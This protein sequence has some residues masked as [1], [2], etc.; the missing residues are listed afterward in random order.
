[1]IADWLDKLL[2]WLI[3]RFGGLELLQ[4]VLLWLTLQAVG[5]GFAAVTTS[6]VPIFMILLVTISTLAAWA[7]ARSRLSCWQFTLA[8]V[9]SGLISLALITGQIG[10][11]LLEL[12]ASPFKILIQ[13]FQ[14][15]RANP[16]LFTAAWQGLIES[17]RALAER[18]SNWLHSIGAGVPIT[19]PL[20][21]SFLWGMALW[22]MILWGVWWIQR[23]GSVLVG[24]LPVT[25]VLAFNIYYT[26]SRAG[27]SWLALAAGGV[28][29]LQAS[30]HFLHA[31]QR[32]EKHAMQREEA[33]STLA[34]AVIVL[35][36]A[37]VLTGRILPSIPIQK[38]AQSM[39]DFFSEPSDQ[40]LARSLGLE[41]TPPE[42]STPIY[43]T[44]TPVAGSG[45]TATENHVVGPGPKL[46]WAA[47]LF[48]TVEGYQPPPANA[49]ASSSPQY[50]LHYYWR[51]QTYSRYNGRFWSADTARVNEL[52]AGEPTLADKENI[53]QPPYATQVT[54]RITRLQIGDKSVYAAGEL[55]RLDVRALALR[56]ANG[57]LISARTDA[58]RYTAVSRIL[59]ASVDQ[60]RAAPPQYPP[61]I[62]AYLELPENLPSSVRDLALEL[63]ATQP[64]PYDKAAAL[65][66][67]LR[68]YPYSLEVPAP[69]LGRDT[70][71]Y[72]L[73]ELKQGY[74]DYFA[75]A[76]VVMAR[77]VNLPARLVLGYT[78][79]IYDPATATYVV[80]AANAH[81]WAEVYFSGI[82]WV[83]FEPTPS[84]PLL[85]HP[86]QMDAI[87]P[88]ASQ[89][90]AIT[91]SP[92]KPT[93]F[94]RGGLSALLVKW[95]PLI[96]LLFVLITIPFLP[97]ETWYLRLLPA[98]KAL[99]TI[100]ARL[101]R[102][103][104][105]F[106]I[107]PDPARTPYHFAGALSAAAERIAASPAQKTL[108]TALQAGLHTLTNT[109]TRL[110][111]SAHPLEETEKQRA[112]ATWIQLRRL[113]RI[114][115]SKK[116]R[117]G[118][119][120]PR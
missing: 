61:E 12:L 78:E 16:A 13:F 30:A 97:L 35:A 119:V 40:T 87:L 72:F 102:Y 90:P 17:L 104:R 100:F 98:E 44:L 68:Q 55:L 3:D 82:G 117:V 83:E 42:D 2:Q 4:L 50:V 25:A 66:N 116:L 46:D 64:T 58:D 107:S 80:R 9:L 93:A 27:I 85:Y 106:G 36:L 33:A 23:R 99:V 6:L 76:M 75:S 94:E 29:L 21:T 110:L 91:L 60:L 48:I 22:L 10:A 1:M 51:S 69:P 109:Y 77:A 67:Y 114:L 47:V 108:L 59:S 79:G 86:R 118:T 39:R 65:E 89:P 49:Y 26:G 113:L 92:P 32:W 57:E 54:Q 20:V 81:A 41:Q 19:D 103:G 111:F 62:S 38:I 8:G 14:S 45:I 28:L 115:Q 120:P 5:L 53:S 43:T 11:A 95:L 70:V 73:F 101:Y 84:Q 52:A 71:E 63:T 112:I 24:L 34:I 74:C 105:N 31:R 88:S 37:L 96:L 18:F 56:R 7:L 15:Q